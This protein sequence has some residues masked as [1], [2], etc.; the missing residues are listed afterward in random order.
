MLISMHALADQLLLQQLLDRGLG[1]WGGVGLFM[2]T[3]TGLSVHDWSE[4]TVLTAFLCPQ[5]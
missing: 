5:S 3:P 1:W 4:R 2:R